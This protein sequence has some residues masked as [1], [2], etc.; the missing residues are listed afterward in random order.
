MPTAM[1]RFTTRVSPLRFFALTFILSWLVWIPLALSHFGIAFNIPDSTSAMVRLLGVLMP[2]ISALILTAVS[3]EK[4]A[5]RLLL[6]RLTLWRF[7]WK[8]WGAA[9][10]VYPILLAAS[11]LISNS[12]SA[13]KVAI[14]PQDIGALIINIVFLLI[15]VLG[16]EIGWHGIALPAMQQKRNPRLSSLILGG[17]V[18]IWHL[19]FWLLMDTFDQFGLLYLALNLLLVLPMTFYATWFF[20]NT[21]YSLLLLVIFHLGF[22]VINTALLPVTLN[23]GAFGILIAFA[24][25]IMFITL[26]RLRAIPSE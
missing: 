2:A 14:V 19:P 15:A 22:N 11:A 6:K 13:V 17:C 10:L 20:N 18:G 1:S 24:W 4:G 25:V 12:F 26:P 8:W 5:V 21:R 16:E 23:L 9:V 3:G 7:G